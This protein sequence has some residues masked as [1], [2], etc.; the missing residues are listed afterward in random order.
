MTFQPGDLVFV[1]V[2]RGCRY[3][4]KIVKWNQR[5][6]HDDP[7]VVDLTIVCGVPPHDSV[8]ASS[9]IPGK[10]CE[11]VNAKYVDPISKAPPDWQER[12]LI[13]TLLK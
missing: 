8:D 12:G 3:V 6:T 2:P 7:Y 9:I 1:D 5:R 13:D 11:R 4:A 10:Y